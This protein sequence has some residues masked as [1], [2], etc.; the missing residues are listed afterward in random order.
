MLRN[1]INIQ[2][3]WDLSSIYPSSEDWELHLQSAH[4]QLGIFSEL[5]KNMLHSAEDL[6]QTM[7]KIFEI[8]EQVNRIYT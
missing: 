1:E 6:Y 3:T 4:Q 8:G 5:E 7:T 2:D